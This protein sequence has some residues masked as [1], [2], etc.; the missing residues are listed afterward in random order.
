MKDTSQSYKEL[1]IPYFKEVFDLLDEIFK[2]RGIPYYLLGATA[3]SLELLKDGNKP[4]RGTKDIDFAIMISS[5][6]DYQGLV[7]ELELKGFRNVT[8]PWTYYHKVFDIVIDILPFGEVEQNNRVNF[9]KRN[10]DF[11]VLGMRTILVENEVKT[12]QVEEKIVNIPTLEGMVLLKLV[13]WADRPEFRDND[14]TDILLIINK[15]FH[16]NG[17]LIIEEHGDLLESL[18]DDGVTSQMQVSS[19]VLGREAAKYLQRCQELKNRILI[20]LENNINQ[21][22]KSEIARKWAVKLDQPIEYTLTLLEAFL[23]GIK[24]KI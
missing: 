14:L 13:A 10:V 2:K 15:Y 8:D 24:E 17:D 9:I 7:Q 12:I 6:K 5:M 11:H 4:A 23:T 16:K 1:G 22:Y 3:I 21:Q 19:R 18:L 20:V